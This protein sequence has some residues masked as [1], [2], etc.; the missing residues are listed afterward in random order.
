MA[1][2]A[3][4]G[5]L[6]DAHIVSERDVVEV[7]QV[8][9]GPDPRVVTDGQLPRPLDTDPVA[10]QNTL[11]DVR[12]EPPQQRDPHTVRTPDPGEHGSLDHHPEGLRDET[13]A[14]VVRLS[15]ARGQRAA[16]DRCGHF[17]FPPGRA[18]P[19]KTSQVATTSTVAARLRGTP[20]RSACEHPVH[21]LLRQR[22]CRGSRRRRSVTNMGDG[23][24]GRDDEIVY[25]RAVPRD[26]LRADAGV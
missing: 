8:D 11:A 17:R 24:L 19:L 25:Q 12:T 7:V 6:G 2:R 26:R 15:A 10:D 21:Q 16:G 3:D 22:E 18:L 1:S 23:A 13:A 9:V 14:L 5:V 4:V 20:A